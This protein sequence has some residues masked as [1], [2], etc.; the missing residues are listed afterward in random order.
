MR[1]A[2]YG[3]SI[4][5]MVRY[6]INY[7]FELIAWIKDNVNISLHIE[8][9]IG[10]TSKQNLKRRFKDFKTEEAFKVSKI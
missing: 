6:H 9:F 3:E 1:D 7:K 4:H 5:I 2:N 8:V 10:M